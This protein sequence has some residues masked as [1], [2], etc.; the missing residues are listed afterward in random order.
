MLCLS[1]TFAAP[2]LVRRGKLA[3]DGVEDLKDGINS[4]NEAL[5]AILDFAKAIHPAQETLSEDTQQ[6]L[7]SLVF[8]NQVKRIEDSVNKYQSPLVTE[9]VDNPYQ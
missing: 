4:A 2:S 5:L 6:A 8:V 7:R 1:A 3:D 9:C